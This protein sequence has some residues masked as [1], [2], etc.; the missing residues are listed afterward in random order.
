MRAFM[1]LLAIGTALL[2]CIGLIV[3]LTKEPGADDGILGVALALTFMSA[4][5]GL[6][7]MARRRYRGGW[8]TVLGTAALVFTVGC[9]AAKANEY[10][11]SSF[12]SAFGFPA[13]LFSAAAAFLLLFFGHRRHRALSR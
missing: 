6:F 9:V 13:A 12:R 7:F 3:E 10:L 4:G 5:V 2:G 1:F 8:L 11:V